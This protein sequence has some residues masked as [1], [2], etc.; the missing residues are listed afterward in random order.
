MPREIF[1]FNE[2][3]WAMRTLLS[4]KIKMIFHMGIQWYAAQKLLATHATLIVALIGLK[5]NNKSFRWNWLLKNNF[6][7][8]DLTRW[9][10]SHGCEYAWSVFPWMWMLNHKIRIAAAAYS[11]EVLHGLRTIP[12]SL[13]HKSICCNGILVST[14]RDA[15]FDEPVNKFSKGIKCLHSVHFS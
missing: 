8:N 10:H 14:V 4:L 2:Y 1:C 12:D 5:I 13:T 7:L 6:S 3:H 11:R 9:M 15:T